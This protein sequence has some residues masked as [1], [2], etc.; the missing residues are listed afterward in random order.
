MNPLF[1]T[2][3]I[4]LVRAK[5]KGKKASN[6]KF[7]EKKVHDTTIDI[8]HLAKES[9]LILIGIFMASIGLKSFL[10]PNHFIDGGV[11]GISLLTAVITTVPVSVLIFC[12][13]IP[14]V[15][16]GYYQIGKSFALKSILA[17]AILSLSVAFLD[18]PI[19]TEDKL[20]VSVF[21]GFFLGSGIGLAVR[22]G[23]V[24]DGTE[25]LAIY[26]SKKIGLTIGDV[27]FGINVLIFGV[28][29]YVLSVETALYSMLTYLAAS[30]TVDFVIEGM[31]EYVGVTIVSDH[32]ENIRSMI[33]NKM[34]RGVT[35]YTGKR[36]FGQREE[37]EILY[38]VVT[39]LELAGLQTEIE[40]IDADAFLVMNS[41]KDTVGGMIKKKKNKAKSIS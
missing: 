41:V 21:G 40:K 3:I 29:S 15:I 35:S 23:S 16:M 34:K 8:Q 1:Q 17:I 9:V 7:F 14:F 20:L 10:L 33:I 32:S 5:Y 31:E 28:A 4:D 22:G 25:V 24:I 30:K 12:I 36:N 19:V 11:T 39:R 27:I 13:N 37:R 26:L 18:F 2:I 6:T 38:T